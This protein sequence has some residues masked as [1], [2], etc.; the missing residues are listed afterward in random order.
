MLPKPEQ[1]GERYASAF[2]EQGVVLAYQYRPP[3]PD[4][5]IAI[6]ADLIT[7]TPRR[8]LDVGCGTGFIARRLVELADH[9]DALDVSPAMIEEGRRL[10]NGDHPRLDW[11]V[12]R[13]EEVPLSPPYALITTGDSLHWLDWEVA[14]PR[15]AR[16]LS[17]SGWLA[18]VQSGLQATPWDAE[19]LPIIQRYSIY[20]NYQS[21]DIVAELERRGLF[22]KYSQIRTEPVAFTQSL[23]EYVESFHGRASLA[24]ERMVAE[25][26]AFDT[27]VRQLVAQFCPQRVE[28]QIVVDIVWGKPLA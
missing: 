26:A 5:A 9:V 3:Y 8:A 7:E 27:E 20:K 11:I 18:V 21:I 6:L 17:P 14:L 23:D 28:L 24:R 4:V 16:L 10:P 19:L 25:A 15:F 1:F 12:G 13:A 2:Q 22:R